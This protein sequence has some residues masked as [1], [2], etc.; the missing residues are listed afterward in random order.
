MRPGAASA[1]LEGMLTLHR[2]LGTYRNK[3]ARYIALNEFCRGKFI[4]GGYLP[5]A[6][7]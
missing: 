1:A 7:W 6:W 5:G 3:V 4:E 2:G